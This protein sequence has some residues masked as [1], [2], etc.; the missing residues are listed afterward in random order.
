MATPYR[1]CSSSGPPMVTA[2]LLQSDGQRLCP[3]EQQMG[4]GRC[5]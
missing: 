4:A 1:S 5:A 2:R 3:D